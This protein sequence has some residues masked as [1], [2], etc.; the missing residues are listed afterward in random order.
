MAL[1]T[2]CSRFDI[3]SLI[4]E[5]LEEAQRCKDLWKSEPIGPDATRRGARVSRH[6]CD[7]ID[8]L[9]TGASAGCELCLLLIPTGV[10]H[11]NLGFPALFRKNASAQEL[12]KAFPGPVLLGA[13]IWEERKGYMRKSEVDIMLHGAWCAEDI[14]GSPTN[15]IPAESCQMAMDRL[16][17]GK[18]GA[19]IWEEQ[20][21]QWRVTVMSG[22][23]V[24]LQ[25]D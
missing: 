19:P 21:R 4:T 11:T 15:R 9:V 18:V 6:L 17:Q 25:Q 13:E 12:A 1:C 2:N 7:S 8:L 16:A 24:R 20:R 22:K 23:T 14:I 10:L 3:R 5:Y